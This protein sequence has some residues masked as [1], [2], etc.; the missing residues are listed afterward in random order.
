MSEEI[1]APVSRG[2]E[3]EALCIVE[4]FNST[5]CH[6]LKLLKKIN[7]KT[8]PHGAKVKTEEDQE[9]RTE[10]A[11]TEP[12]YKVILEDRWHAL[13]M[14]PLAIARYISGENLARSQSVRA[15][16]KQDNEEMQNAAAG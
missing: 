10:N 6:I 1:S 9:E 8:S 12:D 3:A 7:G 11:G 16:A 2:D 15:H 5:C 13:C 14:M 4:P